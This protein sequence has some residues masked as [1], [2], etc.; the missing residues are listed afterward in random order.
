ME[1]YSRIVSDVDYLAKDDRVFFS[2]GAVEAGGTHYG[3]VVEF[4]RASR[5]VLFEATITPPQPRFIITF[6]R[7]ER[8]SLYP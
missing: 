4:D 6:H 2:P 1:T 8:L 5:T 7:T 3:K